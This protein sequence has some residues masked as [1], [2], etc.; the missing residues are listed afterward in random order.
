MI[1]ALVTPAYS[2]GPVTVIH[3]RNQTQFV[4]KVQKEMLGA[5]VGIQSEDGNQINSQRLLKRKMIIDF[6]DLPVG[7]YTV[8]IEKDGKTESFEFV[9]N[10]R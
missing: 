9:R 1:L 2:K 4:F 10:W 7:H 8:V 6:T 3:T 5:H